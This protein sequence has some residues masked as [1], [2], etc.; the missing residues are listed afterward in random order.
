MKKRIIAIAA[1]LFVVLLVWVLLPKNNVPPDG[2]PQDNSLNQPG[3]VGDRENGQNAA[4]GD[5]EEARPQDNGEHG[6]YPGDR[7]YVFELM[8]LEGNSVSLSHLT[9]RVVL[10]SFWL[11]WGGTSKN[12]T[13]S[14][15]GSLYIPYSNSHSQSRNLSLSSGLVILDA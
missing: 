3:A 7:A 4:K 10:V 8:D 6:V 14:G 13:R 2:D 15:T 11:I 12:I 1:A 5:L 9:D